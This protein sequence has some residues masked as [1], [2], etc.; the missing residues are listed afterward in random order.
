MQLHSKFWN[1]IPSLLF[2][3]TLL[4][5]DS[6]ENDK[7]S[8]IEG[9][10]MSSVV[11]D[12]RKQSAATNLGRLQAAL[13]LPEA[14][15]FQEMQIFCKN[16]E[17]QDLEAGWRL[18]EK[19]SNDKRKGMYFK[20]EA[21]KSLSAQGDSE[22]ALDF[23]L[24]ACGPGLERDQLLTSIFEAGNLSDSDLHRL[25]AKLEFP[26]EYEAVTHGIASS[27][28]GIEDVTRLRS[29]LASKNEYVLKGASQALPRA[30]WSGDYKS[31]LPRAFDILK[32]LNEDLRKSSLEYFIS[33]TPRIDP[34]YLN[35]QLSDAFGSDYLSELSDAGKDRVVRQL[36]V[37]NPV[38]AAQ[39]FVAQGDEGREFL[40]STFKIW[41]ERDS[42]GAGDWFSK[43]RLTLSSGQADV[44]AGKFVAAALQ[45]NEIDSAKEWASVITDLDIKGA[46]EKSINDSQ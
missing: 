42:R 29:L 26:S 6:H 38:S 15:V 45:H 8:E 41:L 23:L 24:E 27:V 22:Y 17:A 10:E 44:I 39:T 9:K 12:V 4:S 43:N 11:V 34:F 3:F 28:L 14:E 19:A 35:K 1:P 20:G 36:T 46:V 32:G 40:Q 33:G 37:E 13:S 21:L 16:F 7:S 30:A 18:I 2:G 5:C 25:M 31:G